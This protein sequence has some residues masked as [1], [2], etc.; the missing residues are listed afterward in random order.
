[1]AEKEVLSNH[2]A[3]E[4]QQHLCVLVEARQMQT[5]ADLARDGKYI[6]GRCGRVAAKPENL[7][8]PVKL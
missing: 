7:C 3:D 1:M 8:E 5:V 4:H 6:C 2:V